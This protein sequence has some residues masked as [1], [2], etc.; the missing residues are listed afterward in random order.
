MKPLFY[1]PLLII[2]TVKDCKN[3]NNPHNN[4]QNYSTQVQKEHIITLSGEFLYLDDAAVFKTNTELYGVKKDKMMHQLDEKCK[5]FKKEKYDMIPVVVKA[6]IKNNPNAEGWKEIITIKEIVS[7]S[8]KPKSE[9]KI[10]TVK[11]K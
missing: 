6:I 10:S 11:E 5:P 9:T 7:V 8:D 4:S 3:Q 2:F 1:L